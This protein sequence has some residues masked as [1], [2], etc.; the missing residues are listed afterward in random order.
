MARKRR[1]TRGSIEI[2]VWKASG[3]DGRT[4]TTASSKI[5]WN[6]ERPWSLSS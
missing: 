2:A 1:S 4:S 6:S 5:R 3:A